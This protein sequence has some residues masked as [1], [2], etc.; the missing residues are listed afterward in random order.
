MGKSIKEQK[1]ELMKYFNKNLA[2]LSLNADN[3]D[4]QDDIISDYVAVKKNWAYA[5][6]LGGKV[7]EYS[8]KAYKN[9]EEEMRKQLSDYDYVTYKGVLFQE[10]VQYA[11]WNGFW[12]VAFVA[13]TME[14]RRVAGI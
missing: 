1:R 7:G 2:L 3:G 12:E 10:Y 14:F 13:G 4:L 5:A 9:A 11:D 6:K 8:E